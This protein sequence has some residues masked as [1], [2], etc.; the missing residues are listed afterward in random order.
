VLDAIGYG[1]RPPVPPL[2]LV[3]DFGGGGMLLAFGIACA[4][5]EASVSGTGQVVDASVL[6]G[7]LLLATMIQQMRAGGTWV[8]R[9]MSNLLDG[10]SP[11]YAVYETADGR[12]MALGALEDKFFGE[13]AELIGLDPAAVGQR[14]DPAQWPE[15]RTAIASSFRTRSC[16]EWC[17]L[18][19][20]TDA[21]VTPVLAFDEVGGHPHNAERR[22]VVQ[23]DG[24]G[25]PAPAPRFSRTPGS[26]RSTAP[27]SGRDTVEV[28]REWGV[29]DAL[30]DGWRANAAI[31]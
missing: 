26:V 16:Q 25:Q 28:L 24:F 19:E 13:F 14:H 15:L 1:D 4:L 31:S 3:G 17:D 10:G 8:D 27:P 2:N 18:F 5:I 11:S 20:S 12:H 9:R 7:T 21:C 30:V 29:A 23:V 22:V 6:D